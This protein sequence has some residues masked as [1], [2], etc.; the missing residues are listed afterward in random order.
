[1]FTAG[2]HRLLFVRNYGSGSQCQAQLVHDIDTGNNLIRKVTTHRL[3]PTT[4]DT[5]PNW[6]PKSPR[7]VRILH[8][9][10][11]T[12]NPPEPGF[13]PYLPQCYGHEYIK[14]TATDQQGRPKYHSVSYWKLYNGGSLR[15]RWL[16]DGKVL[17]PSVA[18]AR[19]ARQVL[20]TL[21]YLYTAGPQPIYHED[22]H[23]GNIWAHWTPDQN[24]PDFYLGDLADA[25]HAD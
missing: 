23:F 12:F 14:S 16:Q 18:V 21:H 25:G 20:S 11:Q 15:S 8:T 3:V 10:R 9:I 24:L 7:E 5:V 13:N 4:D 6:R 22:T 2:N 1:M 19:M 17:P